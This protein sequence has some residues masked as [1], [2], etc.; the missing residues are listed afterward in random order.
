MRLD[1][2]IADPSGRIALLK[3][4]SPTRV[5][6]LSDSTASP[7]NPKILLNKEQVPFNSSAASRSSPFIVFPGTYGSPSASLTTRASTSAP[8]ARPEP[9]CQLE[10]NSILYLK[11]DFTN[12]RKN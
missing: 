3:Y 11:S 6:S 1:A 2:I 5:V 4:D 8:A 12:Q 10:K 9:Q 7:D